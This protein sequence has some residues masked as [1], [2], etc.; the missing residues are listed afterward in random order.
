ME[1]DLVA[2][3]IAWY[4]RVSDGHYMALIRPD[5]LAPPEG[6]G[7][8]APA[9][10]VAGPWAAEP[11]LTVCNMDGCKAPPVA[12][13]SMGCQN[14]HVFE[15]SYCGAHAMMVNQMPLTCQARRRDKPGLSCDAKLVVA[16][17]QYM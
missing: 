6:Y 5:P 9:G 4:R 15:A 13:L 14:E 1:P 7:Q 2:D 11:D 3:G 12:V 8:R 17:A 16:R 10:E